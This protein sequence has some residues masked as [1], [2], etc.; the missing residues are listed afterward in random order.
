MCKFRYKSSE[1][2]EV[3]CIFIK[4]KVHTFPY[5]NAIHCMRDIGLYIAI[6]IYLIILHL[7]RMWKCQ[8]NSCKWRDNI[9]DLVPL[10]SPF[11]FDVKGN[12]SLHEPADEFSGLDNGEARRCRVHGGFMTSTCIVRIWRGS[13]GR[14][15]GQINPAGGYRGKWVGSNAPK[16]LRGPANGFR[17]PFRVEL[18]QAL[19]KSIKALHG[20][21]YLNAHRNRYVT[22]DNCWLNQ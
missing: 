2:I 13:G 1:V 6:T 12:S 21:K 16:P 5:L 9:A 8:W 22:F 14:A 20:W 19:I 18:Y 3:V 4:H 15:P 17:Y 7:Y 11:R 10:L